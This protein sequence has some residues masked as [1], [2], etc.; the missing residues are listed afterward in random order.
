[1]I[2]VLIITKFLI[3][4]KNILNLNGAQ[5]LNNNEQKSINGGG[6]RNCLSFSFPT[7]SCFCPLPNGNCLW[8]EPT[9]TCY[10]G[11]QP[12]CP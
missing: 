10:N 3:M 9:A 8:V 1:M 11:T 6:S 7:P 5:E 4:L 12:L 2:T